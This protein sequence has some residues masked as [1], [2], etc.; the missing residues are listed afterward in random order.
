MSLCNFSSRDDFQS[1][2]IR[3]GL[4][5]IRIEEIDGFFIAFL[6]TLLIPSYPLSASYIFQNPFLC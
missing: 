5:K 6:Q 1:T 2:W 4:D 3:V